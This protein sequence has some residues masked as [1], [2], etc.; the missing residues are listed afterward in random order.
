MDLRKILT[1]I[2]ALAFAGG[3][4]TAVTT[5]APASAAPGDVIVSETFSGGTLPS[6]WNA[7]D[8]TWS[9]QNG[10]LVGTAANGANNKITFGRKLN[11]F[12][13]E[14]DVRFD[15]V[16]STSRWAALGLDVPASG[17]TPW[18]IA[19]MRSGSTASNGLEFAQRTTAN[20][21]NVTDT[22]A[23]PYAA[24]TGRNVKVSIE[25]HGTQAR[26]SFDG[27]EVMRTSSLV[28]S[29]NGGQA[30]FVNGATV[31][32]DNIKITELP[33]NAHL[34]S[35]GAPVTVIAH[36]GASAAAPENTLAA[37]DLALRAGADLIENDVQPS[38]DGVPFVLHDSTVDRTT[39]GTGAIRNR[40]S[41]Y[42]KT[43]DA[44]SWFS[45]QYAGERMPTLAEQLADLR[46]RGGRLLLEIKGSHTKAQ[47][48]KII[49][50]IRAQQMTPHVFVQ[51]FDT[52]SLRY[53][54]ELAPELPLGLL[55]STLDADPAAVA[56]DLGLTA[57]NPSASALLARPSA[58]TAL[59]NADIAV[60]AW[61]SDSPT[62]WT[63]LEAAGVDGIITNKP[64]DLVAW[65]QN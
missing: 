2:A 19:T 53:V 34:R 22:A 9:V 59:H 24:G 63:S 43:L 5:S 20:T 11:D 60:M 40:T 62:Q 4:L 31:S 13:F 48:A 12:R 45:P 3:T 37:Q 47:V 57:Y 14:A 61:T 26:W 44:G 56:A 15:S 50:V 29:A 55:R 23:A 17:A 6:G 52:A 33:R 18:W 8:G 42:L 28:R 38:S 46:A 49:E 54:R 10:R 21:W 58:I 7:V 64:A 25:V 39:D 65:N 16:V 27:T 1:G 51:S 36:R 32:F 35:S 30:L 41:A